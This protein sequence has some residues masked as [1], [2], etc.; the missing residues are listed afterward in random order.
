M[1][2]EFAA[3]SENMRGVKKKWKLFRDLDSFD[4]VS[5]KQVQVFGLNL[6]I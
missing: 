6:Q 3:K 1:K 2:W 5:C 4:A